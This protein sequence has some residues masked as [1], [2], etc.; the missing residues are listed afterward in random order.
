MVNEKYI[1]LRKEMGY[2]PL[3][4]E[5][6]YLDAATDK[7]WQ[8]VAIRLN[9]HKGLLFPYQSTSKMGIV[10][11]GN[12]SYCPY[13]GPYLK[14]P[15]GLKPTSKLAYEKKI[16]TELIDQLP[17]GQMHNF[18]LHPSCTNWLPFH[19]KDYKSETRYS[20]IIDNIEAQ[21]LESNLDSKIRGGIKKGQ[22]NVTIQQ[23]KNV[24]T[25]YELLDKVYKR[26]NLKNPHKHVDISR[27]A[28][29][30]FEKNKGTIVEGVDANGVVH[31]AVFLIWDDQSAYTWLTGEDPELRSSGSSYYVLWESILFAFQ[32][33]KLER[34]DFL[35]SMI[36]NIELVRRRYGAIQTPYFR[37]HKTNSKLVRMINAIKG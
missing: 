33:L 30:V 19:W 11:I 26:Q 9:E 14:Y 15:D 34:F 4:Y 28:K 27:I 6:W 7:N 25:F 3:F 17:K 21:V 32:E 13:G 12:G 16:V 8:S 20:Y 35:G 5:P 31:S 24:D 22:K 36:E 1:D 29:A 37:V 18:R 10:R 2:I 23:S